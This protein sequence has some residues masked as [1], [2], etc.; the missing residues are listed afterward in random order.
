MDNVVGFRPVEL[1]FVDAGHLGEIAR[2]RGRPRADYIAHNA[3]EEIAERLNA[4]EAAWVAGEFTRLGKLSRSLV[5]VSDQM[6]METLSRVAAMVAE[7]A[8]SR[9]DL[10]LAALV[11][12]MV[13][14]GEGSLSAIWDIGHLRL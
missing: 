5:G 12:R 3:I 10:A 8:Q 6:G 2:D 4:A 13:R 1:I 11:A 7:N 14:V 9:D